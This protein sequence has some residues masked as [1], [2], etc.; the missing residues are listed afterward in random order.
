MLLCR[1]LA[2][3]RL[4]GIDEVENEYSNNKSAEGVEEEVAEAHRWRG[5]L[6]HRRRALGLFPLAAARCHARRNGWSRRWAAGSCL[7]GF[8]T[9]LCPR[10]GQTTSNGQIYAAA[11]KCVNAR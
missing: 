6:T 3:C 1:D 9:F 7:D 5:R 8:V 2:F 4:S 10:V 11:L